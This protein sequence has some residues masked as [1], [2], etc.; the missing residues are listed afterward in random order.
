MVVIG[1]ACSLVCPCPLAR[2][3]PGLVP[4]LVPGLISTRTIRSKPKELGG[5]LRFATLQDITREKSFKYFSCS[6]LVNGSTDAGLRYDY[7]EKPS[8]T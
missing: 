2:T 4:G 5:G 8:K 6:T 7:E 3:H 1:L